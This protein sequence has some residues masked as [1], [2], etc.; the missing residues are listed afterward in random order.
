MAKDYDE[1]PSVGQL[2][3]INGKLHKHIKQL[4][5]E[6]EQYRWIPVGERLPEEPTNPDGVQIE[7]FALDGNIRTMWLFRC[8][9][10]KESILQM[11][12]THWM[13]IPPLLK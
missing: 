13:P 8:E 4:E 5:A 7:L 6:L 2:I 9:N 11:G 10:W 1:P 3:A 12:Y